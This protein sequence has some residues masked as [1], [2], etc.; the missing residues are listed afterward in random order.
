M[1]GIENL[2]DTALSNG[3][4]FLSD[5]KKRILI[6]SEEWFEAWEFF[7]KAIHEEKIIKVHYGGDKRNRW[8]ATIDDR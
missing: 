6:N 4:N 3:G 8:Y 5:D 1:Y 2:I 7:R